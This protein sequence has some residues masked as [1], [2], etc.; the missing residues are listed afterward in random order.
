MTALKTSTILLHQSINMILSIKMKLSSSCTSV[1]KQLTWDL[2]LQVRTLHDVNFQYVRIAFSLDISQ[3]QIWYALNHRL[4]PQ[5]KLSDS[6]SMINDDAEKILIDFVCAS[7][8]HHR[9]SYFRVAYEL[10]WNVSERV[11]QHYLELHD[12]RRHETRRKSYISKHNRLARL[13]WAYEHLSWTREQWNRILWTDE[14]WV[15]NR[16]G[17]I[18]V[19]R[20]AEEEYDD[21]CVTDKKAKPYEWLFWGCFSDELNLGSELFW[22]KSWDFINQASYVKHTVSQIVAWI[23]YIY[24]VKDRECFANYYVTKL[25]IIPSY[26]WCRTTLLLTL[27]NTLSRFYTKQVFLSYFGLH[28]HPIWIQ[29]SR[30]ETSWRIESQKII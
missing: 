26:N 9:M 20:R 7:R 28:I 19:T 11:V 27:L 5:N 15:T 16:H 6:F 17:K 30:Y 14:T 13:T 24:S 23:R 29:S 3:D 21:T 1:C 22:E 2:R 8:L 25:E 18:W 10:N 12:F 4:T